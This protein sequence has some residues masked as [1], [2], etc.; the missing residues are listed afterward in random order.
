VALV[1]PSFHDLPRWK[2][3]WTKAVRLDSLEW[4]QFLS[5]DLRFRVVSV[6]PSQPVDTGP[7]AVEATVYVKTRR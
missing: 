6:E 4:E 1:V 7:I 3:P 2:A 5:N